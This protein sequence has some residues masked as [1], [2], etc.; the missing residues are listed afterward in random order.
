LEGQG[1]LEVFIEPTNE[2]IR[3]LSAKDSDEQPLDAMTVAQMQKATG[4]GE[5]KI[6]VMLRDLINQGRVE[7]VAVYIKAIHGVEVKSNGY[8]VLNA[9]SDNQ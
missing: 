8:R 9:A 5:K 1:A 2:L 6:R 7:C 4:L 3:L